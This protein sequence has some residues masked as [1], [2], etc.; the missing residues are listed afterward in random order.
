MIAKIAKFIAQIK[1]IIIFEVKL[2][3]LI[4]ILPKFTYVE[5]YASSAGP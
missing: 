1:I 3:N 5:L 2:F 4:S